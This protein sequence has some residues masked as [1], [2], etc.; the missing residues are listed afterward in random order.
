MLSWLSR[1]RASRRSV[2][3]GRDRCLGVP[4]EA[5]SS[6]ANNEGLAM[7]QDWELEE[8]VVR[9]PAGLSGKEDTNKTTDLIRRSL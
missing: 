9:A 5:G 8:I 4:P 2:E 7:T 6:S 3:S 1:A